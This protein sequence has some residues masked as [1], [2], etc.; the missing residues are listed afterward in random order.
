MIIY[1]SV[2]HYANVGI[3]ANR[4]CEWPVHWVC[5]ECGEPTELKSVN[6]TVM[7]LYVAREFVEGLKG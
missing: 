3:N 5:K 1:K 2:C 7:N 6:E 4:L